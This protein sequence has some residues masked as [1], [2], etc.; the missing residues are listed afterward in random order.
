MTILDQL[1]TYL[2]QLKPVNI[3]LVPD[4]IDELISSFDQLKLDNN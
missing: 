3:Q 2:H 1:I 4:V